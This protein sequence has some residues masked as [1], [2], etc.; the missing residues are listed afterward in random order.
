MAPV[1]PLRHRIA[2]TVPVATGIASRAVVERFALLCDLAEEDRGIHNR[3]VGSLA[4]IIASGL[5]LSDEDAEDLRL[6]AR[7]HDVGVPLVET[8]D[9]DGPGSAAERFPLDRANHCDLGHQL[10]S[11]TGIPLLDVAAEIALGHHERWDGRGRPHGV[12]GREVPLSARIVALADHVD[13]LAGRCLWDLAA[14]GRALADDPGRHDPEL[15]DAWRSVAPD[16]GPTAGAPARDR[17]GQPRTERPAG[18][19]STRRLDGRLRSRVL[20]VDDDPDWTLALSVALHGPETEVRARAHPHDLVPADLDWCEVAVV[21]WVFGGGVDGSAASR[22]V[23]ER[24][25]EVP[26]LVLS[27][28]ADYFEAPAGTTVLSKDTPMHDLAARILTA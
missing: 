21:D 7:L 11:G 13:R 2:R 1:L 6:A 8:L 14:I 22:A 3:S 16:L 19:D 25:P 23:H 9:E 15:L 5:G 26:V 24:R 27:A 18:S 17:D 20:V 28:F 4:G 12:D 10:L